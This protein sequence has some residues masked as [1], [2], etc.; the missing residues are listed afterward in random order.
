VGAK[1]TAFFF[2]ALPLFSIVL[3]RCGTRT[4]R[5]APLVVVIAVVA[6]LPWLVRNQLAYGNA[7]FPFAHTLLGHGPWSEEQ[8]AA[9]ARGHSAGMPFVER[10]PLLWSQWIAHGLGDAPAPNEPWSPQWGL[11]PIAGLVGLAVE[12]RR[13][14]VARA[15]LAALAIA[16]LGWLLATHLKSRFLLPTAVP[17]TVGAAMLVSRVVRATQPK[18]AMLFL[19]PAVLL[20]FYSFWREP[21][22]PLP[23]A[24]GAP[25]ELLRAPATFIGDTAFMTGERLAR[26]IESADAETRAKLA[27]QATTAYFVNFALP[28][29]ARVLAI[30]YSTPFY[31]RRPIAWTTVW[32]RGALDA[33]AAQNPGTPGVWGA[34]LRELGYTHLIVQPTMLVVW[35]QSGWINPD[36]EPKRWLT[37]FLQANPTIRT[38]DGCFIVELRGAQAAGPASPAAQ[39]PAEA[40]APSGL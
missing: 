12:V 3:L 9:F 29:E 10:L 11:L 36:L 5:F 25:A 1:P 20:P 40:P 6:L 8:F 14:A 13:S 38:S 23:T 15:A 21:A 16:L 19:T 7:L 35:T 4:L 28:A 24:P 32:D 22:K 2:V 27:P 33:V 30:G 18:A 17:L 26:D 31:L 39:V 37:A 34:K